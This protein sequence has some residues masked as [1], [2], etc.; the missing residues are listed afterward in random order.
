MPSY[1]DFKVGDVW[2]QRNGSECTI[3]VVVTDTSETS[4]P[5][6]TKYKDS[7]GLCSWYRSDGTICIDEPQYD[8][9]R[10]KTDSNIYLSIAARI[11]ASQVRVEGM[12]AKNAAL[13]RMSEPEEYGY[14]D[15]FAEA[16]LL[17]QL[18]DEAGRVE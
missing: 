4:Y 7:K 6:A 9:I 3:A 11:A 14:A 8:L 10:K 2:I 1:E 17:E 18:A 16:Q 13:L 12:K 5:I 15:F